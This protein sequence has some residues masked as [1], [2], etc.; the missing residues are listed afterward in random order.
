MRRT[1][2]KLNLAVLTL[3]AGLAP[4]IPGSASV[5]EGGAPAAVVVEPVVDA[6]EVPVGEEVETTFEIRNDGTAPL[7]ITRV[8]PACGCTV[9]DYDEVIAPGETGLVRATLDTT[10]IL[11]PN[12]KAVTVFTNDAASPRIQLTIKSDVRPFLSVEPGYA[13]FTSFVR[14]EGGQTA[15]QLLSAPDF[16]DLEVLGVESP[17][18]WIDV[19]YREASDDEGTAEATGRQWRIDVTLTRDAPVGPVADQILVRTN[20]PEQETVE[21]PVS[22]FV[23]PVVAV[24]PSGVDFGRIDPEEEQQWGILVRNFGSAP[25][26]IEGVRSDVTGLRIDVEPIEEGER[27]KLVFTPTV[28]LGE[29]SFDGTVE[30]V[31][32]LPSQPTISV[33]VKGERI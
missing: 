27:Y 1:K 6:G 5:A 3:L 2:A 19:E 23:R 25:L 14:N 12:A 4:I 11:G 22:A 31:T 9:A 7:E 17:E 21:I 30:V 16:E 33:D 28:E 10:S 15:S 26:R 32:N 29:G 20:H 24:T 13:R 18:P 8:Q